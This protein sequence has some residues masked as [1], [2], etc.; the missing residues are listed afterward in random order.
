MA[1]QGE[2]APWFIPND[3]KQVI[4]LKHVLPEKPEANWP[5]FDEEKTKLY[6]KR[7][8]NL[9]LLLAKSNSDLRNADFKTKK[10][11]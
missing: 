11:I 8:G 4:N 5:S 3:D 1:A 10:V 2:T 7:L 9:A 6:A